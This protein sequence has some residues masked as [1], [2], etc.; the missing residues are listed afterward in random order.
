MSM[1]E[2]NDVVADGGV[3][4]EEADMPLVDLSDKY[5]PDEEQEPVNHGE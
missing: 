5:V 3:P 2:R 4:V 1:P